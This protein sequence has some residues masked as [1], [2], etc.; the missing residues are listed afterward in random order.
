MCG[1]TARKLKGFK[2]RVPEVPAAGPK[3]LSETGMGAPTSVGLTESVPVAGGF[4]ITLNVTFPKLRSYDMPNPPRRLD[5][6][7]PNTSQAN[8]NRGAQLL[9]FLSHNPP[10]GL[11]GAMRVCPARTACGVTGPL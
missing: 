11:F 10:T 4:W 6:P 3:L 8:P 7:V 9:R 5:F 2:G 1:S